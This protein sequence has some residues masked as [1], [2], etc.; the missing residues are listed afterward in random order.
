[1]KRIGVSEGTVVDEFGGA[2]DEVTFF[3]DVNFAGNVR[4]TGGITKA[5]TSAHDALYALAPDM[6]SSVAINAEAAQDVGVP[7]YPL[8]DA[9]T[10][11]CK[12]TWPIPIGW[13]A[14]AFRWGWTN[15]GAGAGNVKWQFDYKLIYL[16]EG[17]VDA[18]ATTTIAIPAIAADGQFDF[19]Y[20]LPTETQNISLPLGGFGDSPFMLCSL[21]RLGADGTDTL[22]AT[23]SVIV[24]SLTRV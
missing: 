15:E 4:L 21:S 24:A 19:K 6:T 1:M 13:S 7:R 14:G 9:A 10:N 16:G 8:V 23:A 5:I 12:W 2:L 3:G 17:D 18:G 11:R 22:A 20:S